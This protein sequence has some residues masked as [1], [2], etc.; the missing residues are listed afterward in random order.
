MNKPPNGP[1]PDSVIRNLESFYALNKSDDKTLKG[2]VQPP[3]FDLISPAAGKSNTLCTQIALEAAADHNL[4]SPQFDAVQAKYS[5]EVE[6]MLL[7]PRP[8]FDS[9]QPDLYEVTWSPDGKEF[10]IDLAYALIPKGWEAPR[11]KRRRIPVTL[12]RNLSGIGS[13]LYLDLK[14]SQLQPYS[15]RRAG[16]KKGSSPAAPDQQAAAAKAEPPSNQK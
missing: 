16:K 5:D 7:I 10:R 4:P 15:K 3:Y 2:T 14:A 6:G 11:E 9:K 1:V 8:A 12:L 13:A